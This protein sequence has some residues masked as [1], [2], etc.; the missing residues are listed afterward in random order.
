[1][2]ILRRTLLRTLLRRIVRR[3][4]WRLDWRGRI[5]LR[6]ASGWALG[7][8]WILWRALLLRVL[9]RARVGRI[10][11]PLLLRRIRLWIGWLA[12]LRRV[13]RRVPLSAIQVRLAHR[14]RS[15]CYILL[16]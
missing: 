10:V 13:Q 6:C 1:R 5:G 16:P 4:K 11:W 7:M 2:R 14:R 8:L 9:R 15:R 12:R 3:V